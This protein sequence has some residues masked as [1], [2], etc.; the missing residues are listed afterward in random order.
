MSETI[1]LTPV[2]AV[3]ITILVD[4]FMD[5]LMPSTAMVQRAPVQADSFEREELIAEH[6]FSVLLTI[7]KDGRKQSLL[8]DA[9]LGQHSLTH[10]MD[11][12]GIQ[13][14][15]LR[16]MV[17]SHGH[18]DHHGGLPAFLKRL[19]RKQIPLVLHPDAWRDRNARFPNG[20]ELHLPPPSRADLEREGVEVVERRDP[21]LLIDNM[22]LVTGQVERVTDFEK[23][24]PGHFARQDSEWEADPWIWDDQAIV[25]NVQDQGLVVVSGCS[26]A[27]IINVLKY[28]RH[29]TGIEQM[30]TVM[31]GFH[32]SGN[33][34][35]KIIGSTVDNLAA[36]NPQVIVPCHC[37]GWKAVHAIAQRMPD[38]FVQSCVGTRLCL[39]ASK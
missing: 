34:F 26:H 37:T 2:D 1:A 23:G 12:L 39:P 22:V 3:E 19:N 21:S 18:T 36:I 6:G 24:M 32:L 10:N 14:D 11:V 30:Y 29:L 25:V 9:G 28:T 27:G 20:N 31:G 5:V 17:L 38:A 15:D 16:A 13:I 4:N 35:E 33:F 8:Y 7:Q